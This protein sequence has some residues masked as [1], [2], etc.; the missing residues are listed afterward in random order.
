MDPNIDT[1]LERIASGEADVLEL[2]RLSDAARS[3]KHLIALIEWLREHEA[4][5]VAADVGLDTRRTE[6]RQMVALLAEVARWDRAPEK[7]RGRPGLLARDPN[8]AERIAELRGRGLSLN[9]IADRLNDDGIQTPRGGARW[10]ASSVQSAL[11]YRRPPPPPPG[12][13]K[14]RKPPGARK[15]GPRLPPKP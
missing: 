11:G 9:Q 15:P 2:E 1:Q 14:P 5:L 4:H 3:L 7:P 8:L 12:A 13:P 10:R 6:G